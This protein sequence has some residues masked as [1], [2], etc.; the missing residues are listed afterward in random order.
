M[1]LTISQAFSLTITISFLAAP[2]LHGYQSITPINNASK[3]P[4]RL[5]GLPKN[6][7]SMLTIAHI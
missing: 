7:S 6:K 4:R 1:G 3:A 5:F 2:T